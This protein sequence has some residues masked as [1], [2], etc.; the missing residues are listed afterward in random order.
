MGDWLTPERI[1]S[2]AF[3]VVLLLGALG[4]GAKGLWVFGRTYNE[5][6]DEKD[7]QIKTLMDRVERWEGVALKALN[8]GEKLADKAKVE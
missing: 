7:A 3:V 2:I 4:A 8:V 1:G 6:R 5:M